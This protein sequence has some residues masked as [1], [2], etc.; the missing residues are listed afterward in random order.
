MNIFKYKIIN[1]KAISNLEL[2]KEELLIENKDLVVEARG[3][4]KAYESLTN[5]NKSLER[6]IQTL[7]NEKGDLTKETVALASEIKT[8]QIRIHE[9]EQAIGELKS[10]RKTNSTF[11]RKPN[12]NSRKKNTKFNT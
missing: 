9:M 10:N 7:V 12:K 2:L 3:Y 8:Y 5:A 1:T 4:K 6:H 11:S